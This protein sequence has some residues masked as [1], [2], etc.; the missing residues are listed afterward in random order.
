MSPA[1]TFQPKAIWKA[2]TRRKFSSRKGR[3]CQIF[4]CHT[5]FNNFEFLAFA[6]ETHGVWSQDVLPFDRQLGK[7][8][9][10]N[11]HEPR[12]TFDSPY[13]SPFNEEIPF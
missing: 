8:L 4:K 12:H 3:R 9:I 5:L 2:F 10:E 11:T 6:V 7:L 1:P 13:P